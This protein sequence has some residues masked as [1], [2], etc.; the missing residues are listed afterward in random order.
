MRL[1]II[2]AVSLLTACTSNQTA[3]RQQP[4]GLSQLAANVVT[5]SR[6]LD[7]ATAAKFKHLK[8]SDNA[9]CLS[10]ANVIPITQTYRRHSVLD[11]CLRAADNRNQGL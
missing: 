4:S 2:A 9:E 7:D 8:A 11:G 6:E 5:T 10:R 3:Y 1:V